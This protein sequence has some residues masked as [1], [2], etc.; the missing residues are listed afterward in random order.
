MQGNQTQTVHLLPI[1]RTP[2][3]LENMAIEFTN[4]LL[5]HPFLV[6]CGNG[7]I[8]REELDRLLIQQGKY[9]QYFTRY[10]C[11][12]I[13]QLDD[14]KD[15]TRLAENLSEELGYDDDLRIPHSD[16][17]SQMLK[18]LGLNIEN[19]ETLPE[20]QALI[21]SMFM[22]CRQPGGVPGL[23]A[24]CLG[25]EAVVPALYTRILEGF[26]ANHVDSAYLDFFT[27]HIECDDGHA[28]TMFD[29][30]SNLLLTSN[31]SHTTAMQ[32][33]EIVIN[34]RLRMFDALLNKA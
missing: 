1:V 17:Y 14:A 32:A 31:A 23:A 34:A 3:P 5:A 28:E 27:I 25:A 24:M 18:S 8:T 20:T 22:L 7:T 15:V 29:I 19:E 13:S 4:R 6:R 16:I 11:A 21:D 9:S 2:A 12:L 30:L 26:H 10:L 33:G